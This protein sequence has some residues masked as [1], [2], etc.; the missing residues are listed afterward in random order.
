MALDARDHEGRFDSTRDAGH[1]RE[2]VS[3]KG[4]ELTQWPGLRGTNQFPNPRVPRWSDGT[5]SRT[6]EHFAGNN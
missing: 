4:N 1:D 3:P 6:E 5:S 2:L